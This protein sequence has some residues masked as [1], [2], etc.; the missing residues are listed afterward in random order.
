MKKNQMRFLPEI[1]SQVCKFTA[2]K[3]SCIKSASAMYCFKLSSK[4][5]VKMGKATLQNANEIA[6]CTGDFC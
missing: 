4:L 2:D 1:N 6:V 3:L 5:G